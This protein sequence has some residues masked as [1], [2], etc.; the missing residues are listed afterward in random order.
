V[1]LG[2]QRPGTVLV[3]A[4]LNVGRPDPVAGGAAVRVSGEE[5]IDG[6]QR[7]GIA[8]ILC[9]LGR[10]ASLQGAEEGGL[11][12]KAIDVAGEGVGGSDGELCG[13]AGDERH[14]GGVSKE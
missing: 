3:G 4:V 14:C 11:V 13:V 7:V 6:L 12:G 1:N 9:L 8:E 10:W 5:V 2:W